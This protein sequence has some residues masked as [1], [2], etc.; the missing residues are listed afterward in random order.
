MSVAELS[1]SR[2]KLK[3]RHYDEVLADARRAHELGY[4]P[5]GNWSL[6]QA[7]KHLGT[8]MNGSVDGVPFPVPLKTRILGRWLFRYVILYWKFP[9]GARLP[10]KAAAVLVPSRE[11]NF[12]EALVVLEKGIARLASDPRRI[13]HPVIGPLNA[14]QWDRFHLNHAA[15]HLSFFVPA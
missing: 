9:P 10:K 12:S 14:R 5:L 1:R 8:A 15:L 3:F 7:V 2:R 4:V 11:T 13:A 6:G